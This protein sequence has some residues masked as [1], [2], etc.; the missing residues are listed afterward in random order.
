MGKVALLLVLGLLHFASMVLVNNVPAKDN[1]MKI[2]EFQQIFVEIFYINNIK[3][4]SEYKC[5][6]GNNATTPCSG[7]TSFCIAGV[8]K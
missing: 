2:V 3:G 7:N 8:C 5:V 1:P 6:C 4:N